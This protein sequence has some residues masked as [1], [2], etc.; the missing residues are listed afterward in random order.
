M[1]A[2]DCCFSGLFLY[3]LKLEEHHRFN[4]NNC[5]HACKFWTPGTLQDWSLNY[6]DVMSVGD[7][8]EQGFYSDLE[9]LSQIIKVCLRLK[10][11]V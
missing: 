8:H 10:N 6:S 4:A 1:D 7:E 2:A 9:F 5:K 3:L 11:L